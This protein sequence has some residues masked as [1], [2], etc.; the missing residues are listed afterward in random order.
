MESAEMKSNLLQMDTAQ[1]HLT[2]GHDFMLYTT[3]DEMSIL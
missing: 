1:V 2:E 3:M